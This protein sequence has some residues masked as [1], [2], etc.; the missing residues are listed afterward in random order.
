MSNVAMSNMAMSNVAM[1]NVAN[2]L[3]G[4]GMIEQVPLRVSFIVT[5]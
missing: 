5:D 2:V 4:S 3:Q 1:S